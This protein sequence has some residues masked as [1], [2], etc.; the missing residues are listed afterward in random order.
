MGFSSFCDSHGQEMKVIGLARW[1]GM[2]EGKPVSLMM[3]GVKENCFLRQ[4]WVDMK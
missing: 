4:P 1:E 3:I 2:G